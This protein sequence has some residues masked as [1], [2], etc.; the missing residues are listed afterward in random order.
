M[1]W[2][3]VVKKCYRKVMMKNWHKILYS[4]K[5]I[6][7]EYAHCQNDTRDFFNNDETFG[8]VHVSIEID[9]QY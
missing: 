7:R 2:R 8:T 1:Y 6:Q 3:C 5:C 4:V 9:H